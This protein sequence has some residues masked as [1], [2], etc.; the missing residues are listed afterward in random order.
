M[1]PRKRLAKGAL[2]PIDND[3]R[4]L[5]HPQ[6][7][8]L[9]NLHRMARY[10]EEDV[11]DLVVVGAGAGGSTLAQ[12]LARRGWRIVV[13]ESGPF[14]D[15]DRDWV[16]DEA[17]ADKLYWTA[18]RVIAGE[19][20]VELGKNN[21]G[22]GVGGSMVHYAGYAPRFHPSDFEVRR[23]DGVGAD[24]PLSYAELRGHYERVEAELP[25]SGQDWPWGDPHRYPYNAHPISG[26]A[27]QAIGGARELGI[28]MRVGPVAIPNGAFGNR[29][30][31]IYRGFCLQ[32]CKVNAKASPLITHLPDAIEH[33]V[34][35]RADSHV[36]RVEVDGGGR[37][38]GVTYDTDRGLRR[39]RAAAVAVCGYSI[40]TPR[41]LLNSTSARFPDGLA[42][43]HDQVGRYIMVQGAP[44]VAGRFPERMHMFK[45]PP[46]EISS[47]QFYETD[48]GRDFVRGFSI[49][50]VG[51]QPIAWAEHVLADG[52]W[53]QALREYMRDYNHWYTLGA[54]SELL[55]LPENRVTLAHE[56]DAHDMPVARLDYTQC[57]NDRANI[58]AAKQTL[59]DIWE[60]AGAQD[61]LTIDRY[62]HLVGGCRMGTDPE[63]SVV[64]ADHRAWGVP[65]LF[66][67][68]GSVMPTQGS[69]N[70]ALTI[71]ALASRLAEQLGDKRVG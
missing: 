20:P 65:N 38:T 6:R 18:P 26:G 56:T 52:H 43:D 67:A 22:H 28:E 35:V 69:A 57:D 48:P 1:R 47:E 29:P 3:S 13:L 61:V 54:L 32:G 46:P 17:G 33:G 8:G 50:T 44:Q 34:E 5:L 16:S 4:Y 53:G 36:V 11:V 71:M 63:T 49:Q 15:P 23:R 24:W 55:P 14:W 40:E 7:R 10:D 45:A 68:D 30:H 62:A 64:D 42:N 19:D 31:C 37:A 39:Q 9:Q 41:L 70:P 21:S 66:I 60:A 2:G 51:P 25:V 59:H 12:R 58:A 27:E